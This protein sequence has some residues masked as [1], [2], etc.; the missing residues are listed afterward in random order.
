MILSHLTLVG[1]AEEI[2]TI[3]VPKKF[4]FTERRIKEEKSRRADKS[5]LHN[6][7]STSYPANKRTA[8][9]LTFNARPGLFTAQQKKRKR[10]MKNFFTSSTIYRTFSPFSILL[11]CCGFWYNGI[12]TKS[13]HNATLE[14][15]KILLSMLYSLFFLSLFVISA[16][17]GQQEPD[18][19]P[20]L[21]K[22][23]WHKLYLIEHLFLPTI[24][25][26]NFYHRRQIDE[27]LQLID[28]YDALCQ[29]RELIC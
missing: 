15:F 6:A 5:S 28:Q 10:K 16:L 23:G 26:S 4:F 11:C 12:I 25:W 29:V 1:G 8:I 9:T 7:S 19:M 20:F 2:I 17:Q 22:H 13:K 21:L 18:S 3:I 24:I 14:N 27:C